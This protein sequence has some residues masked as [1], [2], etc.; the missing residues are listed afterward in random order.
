MKCELVKRREDGVEIGIVR[1]LRERRAGG[2]TDVKLLWL[3]K[4]RAILW[5]GCER[6][7]IVV[8]KKPNYV[9]K[10]YVIEH[11]RLYECPYAKPYV[12]RRYRT[13]IDYVPDHEEE[14][15]APPVFIWDRVKDY[16]MH[17]LLRELRA[18]VEFDTSVLFERLTHVAP[19][20]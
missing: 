3:K 2:H 1:E 15:G 17:D 14:L 6:C 20:G 19:R 13:E 10:R 9:D 12:S 5:R 11:W 16:S 7:E 8:L 4:W 18:M